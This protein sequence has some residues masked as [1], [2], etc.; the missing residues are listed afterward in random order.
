[1]NFEIAAFDS[2]ENN[3][4]AFGFGLV[5]TAVCQAQCYEGRHDQRAFLECSNDAKVN[6]VHHTRLLF[7]HLPSQRRLN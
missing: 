7:S 1:M 3:K 2:A 4:A 6:I 5:V